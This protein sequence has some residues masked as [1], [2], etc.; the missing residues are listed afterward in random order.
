MPFKINEIVFKV[1][2]LLINIPSE[3]NVEF[4]GV[5]LEPTQWLWCLVHMFCP[6]RCSQLN[7]LEDQPKE[8]IVKAY[9]E[10]KKELTDQVE[11]GRAEMKEIEETLRPQTVAEVDELRRKLHTALVKLD[12]RRI[13]LERRNGR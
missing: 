12:T 1:D 13:E 6:K 2:D 9:V 10:L 3:E 11:K 4:D 7:C 5:S 8:E